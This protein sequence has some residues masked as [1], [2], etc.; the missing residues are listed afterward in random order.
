MAL[1]TEE[2][3]RFASG[4]VVL[5]SGKLRDAYM[6]DFKYAND[7]KIVDTFGGQGVVATKAKCSGSIKIKVSEQG[8]ERDYFIMV[9]TAKN[10]SMQFE[11]PTQNIEIVG[12]ASSLDGAVQVGTETELTL[13]YVGIIKDPVT[14]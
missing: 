12:V 7:A 8:P 13:S 11:I 10:I 3:L 2:L 5:G 1:P 6:A 4:Q 9:K 14:I